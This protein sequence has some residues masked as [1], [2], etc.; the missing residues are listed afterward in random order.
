MR[1]F[2]DTFLALWKQ[3]AKENFKS[4]TKEQQEIM[5]SYGNEILYYLDFLTTKN[6]RAKSNFTWL[7]LDLVI[8]LQEIFINELQEDK[9]ALNKGVT[10][11]R[12]NFKKAL[13]EVRKILLINTNI[14]KNLKTYQSLAKNQEAIDNKLYNKMLNDFNITYKILTFLEVG[15]T[16]IKDYKN[17]SSDDDHLLR[18][19]E[20]YTQNEDDYMYS[21]NIKNMLNDEICTKKASKKQ[22]KRY[23]LGFNRYHKLKASTEIQLFIENIENPLKKH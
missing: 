12:Q 16:D 5:L 19:Y 3:H 11:K 20:D 8:D 14:S 17:V 23:L 21:L 10:R 2:E 13:N 18:S 1:T 4:F 22:I 6:A 9:Q 15:V 7:A